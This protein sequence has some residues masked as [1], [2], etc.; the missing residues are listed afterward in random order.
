VQYQTLW[1]VIPDP[2]VWALS[3]A[4]F[5]TGSNTTLQYWRTVQQNFSPRN[6]NLI[7]HSRIDPKLCTHVPRDVG[8][9]SSNT[10]PW[11]NSKLRRSK[12]LLKRMGFSQNSP[13]Q[14]IS[15]LLMNLLES[16]GRYVDL[17]SLHI[18]KFWNHLQ[19]RR[20]TKSNKTVKTG[21]KGKEKPSPTQS[22][23]LDSDLRWMIA[24]FLK[25]NQVWL[26]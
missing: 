8:R 17:G 26:L 10:N 6:Q 7:K 13:Q 12:N 25:I 15:V 3:L 23:N 21:E 19:N 16:L 20:N 11:N 14:W 2:P 24:L 22:K 1:Y 4:D 18:S 9:I 5:S